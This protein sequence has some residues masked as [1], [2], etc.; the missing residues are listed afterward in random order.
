[1]LVIIFL[2]FADRVFVLTRFPVF[3]VVVLIGLKL[4]SENFILHMGEKNILCRNS[5]YPNLSFDS[6]ALDLRSVAYRI[7]LRY[8]RPSNSVSSN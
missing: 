7:D 2:H 4:I 3:V 8:F 5:L 1:M 6:A